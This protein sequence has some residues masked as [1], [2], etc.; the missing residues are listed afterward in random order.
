[1][2]VR[3]ETIPDLINDSDDE[4]E[5]KVNDK[6]LTETLHDPQ[7]YLVQSFSLQFLVTMTL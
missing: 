3:D 6:I 4:G 5:D 7:H 2:E 1:M